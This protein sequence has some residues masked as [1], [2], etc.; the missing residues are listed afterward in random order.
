M[1]QCS[2]QAPGDTHSRC[3]E[4]DNL[5]PQPR[6]NW[7]MLLDSNNYESLLPGNGTTGNSPVANA[8][9][10]DMSFDNNDAVDTDNPTYVSKDSYCVYIL[11]V[12]LLQYQRVGIIDVH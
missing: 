1:S 2:A 7:R 12:I 6:D 5:P 10:N 9:W 11:P 4:E 8:V 3:L